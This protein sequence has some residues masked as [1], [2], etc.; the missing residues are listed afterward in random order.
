MEPVIKAT[1]ITK[2]YGQQEVLKGI[3]IAIAPGDFTCIMDLAEDSGTDAS[4]NCGR[5]FFRR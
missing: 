4:A 1:A 2:K 5:D 3:D